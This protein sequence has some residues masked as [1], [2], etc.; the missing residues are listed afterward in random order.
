MV[1]SG[2][3]YKYQTQLVVL[4]DCPPG[5]CTRQQLTAYRY[6]FQPDPTNE[7]Y[8]PGGIKTPARMFSG[9]EQERCSLLAL[10][11]FTTSTKARKKYRK[12]ARRFDVRT[13][14]GTH[15]AA[16]EITPA[17]GTVTAPSGSGHMDL[18]EFVGA[19]LAAIA[20]I[21]ETL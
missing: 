14:L 16:L 3:A 9:D 2:T 6:V 12:L 17:H 8:L 13:L 5:G 21:V 18:H 19:D 15:L 10:S 4:A 20:V 1:G 11:I 7:S